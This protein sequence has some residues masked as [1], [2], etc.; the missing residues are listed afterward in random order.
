MLL[1]IPAVGTYLSNAGDSAYGVI[2]G[3]FRLLESKKRLEEDFTAVTARF[4]R[5]KI[6][7]RFSPRET[8]SARVPASPG[9]SPRRPASSWKRPTGRLILPRFAGWRRRRR[10]LTSGWAE[11]AL[12]VG[13]PAEERKVTEAA[14][15]VRRLRACAAFS[16]WIPITGCIGKAA[17]FILENA[18]YLPVV[19][20]RKAYENAAQAEEE[21]RSV[22]AIAEEE[23][24]ER[25]YRQ[26][27][28]KPV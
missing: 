9:A 27:D 24:R 20:Y 2:E 25:G 1:E 21:F 22:F 18:P 8:A 4:P 5:G 28:G 7:L 26:A 14:D 16:M 12:L 11:A 19:F 6:T 15:A 23:G 10:R 13:V 3:Y 17:G